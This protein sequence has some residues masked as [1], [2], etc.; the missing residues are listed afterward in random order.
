MYGRLSKTLFF[1]EWKTKF[2]NSCI[3]FFQ[4]KQEDLLY[5]K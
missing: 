3:G 2:G 5:I 1:R 4:T